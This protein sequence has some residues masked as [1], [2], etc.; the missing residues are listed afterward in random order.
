[1]ANKTKIRPEQLTRAR[2]LLQDLPKR[3]EGKTRPEAA[4]FLENDFRKA[5]KKG[6]S[7][8][9]LSQLLKNE[10]II[11]PAYLIQKFLS[12]TADAPPVQKQGKAPAQ[13]PAPARTSFIVP[14]F[15]DKKL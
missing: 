9:E 12:E 5:F 11:I 6:Y 14:D 10:S 15:P 1:M 3:E 13:R 2:K 7:P 8:K 4:E